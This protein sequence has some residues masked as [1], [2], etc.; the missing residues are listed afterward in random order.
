MTWLEGE[1]H[2]QG[3]P[4]VNLYEE[5]E[6]ARRCMSVIVAMGLPAKKLG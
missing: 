6:A 2:A 4:G 5:V 3:A 1:I